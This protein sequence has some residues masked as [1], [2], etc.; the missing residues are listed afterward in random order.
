MANPNRVVKWSFEAPRILRILTHITVPGRWTLFRSPQ[1]SLILLREAYS[2]KSGTKQ[3]KMADILVITV[4]TF[5]LWK[6][7][8]IVPE[9]KHLALSTRSYKRTT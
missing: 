8:A 3:N 9:T 5:S 6:T 2:S 7:G 4:N 1:I